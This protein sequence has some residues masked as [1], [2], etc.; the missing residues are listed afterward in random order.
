MELP[1]TKVRP[2]S[3]DES[4]PQFAA[5]SVRNIKKEDPPWTRLSTL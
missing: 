5:P 4:R 3:A 1:R 2:T